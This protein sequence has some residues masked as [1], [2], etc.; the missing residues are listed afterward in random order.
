MIF[1]P[2]A[3]NVYYCIIY[4]RA[5]GEYVLV[6]RVIDVFGRDGIAATLFLTRDGSLGR[7]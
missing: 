3:L 4:A 5:C 6:L 1:S 7:S 2:Y